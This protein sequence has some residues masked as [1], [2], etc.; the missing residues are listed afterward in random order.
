MTDFPRQIDAEGQE[1]LFRE[2]DLG[3]LEPRAAPG[4]RDARTGE[5]LIGL[6]RTGNALFTGGMNADGSPTLAKGVKSLSPDAIPAEIPWP[7]SVGPD[8]R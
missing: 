5:Q 1:Y 4:Y 7:K 6:Y 8:P 3:R 2:G